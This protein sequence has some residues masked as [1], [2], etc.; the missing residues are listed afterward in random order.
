M[1]RGTDDKMYVIGVRETLLEPRLARLRFNT[2][3]GSFEASYRTAPG[4]S[5]GVVL[6]AG[7][8]GGLDGLGSLYPELARDL[9]ARG[10]A[11]IRLV[12][13]EPHDCRQCALDTLVALQYLDDEGI[14]DIAMVGWSSGGAVALSVGSCAKNVSAIAAVSPQAVSGGCIRRLKSKSVLLL[15]GGADPICP[16]KISHAIHDG[17]LGPRRM[18]VYANAGHSLEEVGPQL[19][20]DLRDWLICALGVET[21]S[22]CERQ[23]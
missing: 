8:E 15:H 14:K 23:A 9:L 22:R 16:V 11:S 10:I 19:F 5:K 4:L 1:F 17:A 3:R 13:R 20:S 2:T 18:I 7:V 21:N 12:A 6:V